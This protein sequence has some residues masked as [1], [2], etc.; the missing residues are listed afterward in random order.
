M[1]FVEGEEQQ[2]ELVAGG[3]AAGFEAPV[4]WNLGYRRVDR[5]VEF[6][7]DRCGAVAGRYFHGEGLCGRWGTGEGSRP[8][9]E[10]QPGGEHCP[11]GFGCRVGQGVAGVR[12]VERVG[13]EP[14][15]E[16]RASCCCLIRDGVRH[17]RGVVGHSNLDGDVCSDGP[18]KPGG[19]PGYGS[20]AVFDGE[21]GVGEGEGSAT[22]D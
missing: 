4:R 9:I 6:V 15:A 13:R 1:R 20:G 18:G 14:I 16:R 7:A 11:V 22:D 19:G 21:G 2:P 5:D 3:E 12:V 8:G 10:H 17:R